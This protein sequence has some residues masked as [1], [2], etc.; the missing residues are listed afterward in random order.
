MSVSRL[1]TGRLS[2]QKRL[3]AG[4]VLLAIVVAAAF[5]ILIL[6][7][8]TL[9][10]ATRQEAQSRDVTAEALT[11]QKLVLDV[12][13]SL[14]G[15]VITGQRSFLEPYDAATKELPERSNELGRLVADEPAQRRRA[16]ALIAAIEDY[17]SDFVEPV[18]AFGTGGLAAARSATD[19]EGTRRIDG[20]R[21]RF[22]SFLEAEDVLVAS[23]AESADEGSKLA[24]ALGVSGLAASAGFILLFALYLARS[25]ARPV[26]E[27]AA[28]AA[29][30]AG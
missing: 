1:R 9:R 2:L 5:V 4:S 24:I 21:K 28:G 27:A 12:E 20:I 3:V 11:L 6:S 26:R 30:L 13:T 16:R 14:R 15:Y 22:D 23:R 8:A 10:E 29:Q 18:L 7:L 19:I 17:I 25:I